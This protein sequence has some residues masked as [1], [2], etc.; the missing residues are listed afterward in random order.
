MQGRSALDTLYQAGAS[1]IL[2][3]RMT[4]QSLTAVTLNTAGGITGGDSFQLTARAGRDSHLTLT[5]QAA[6]RLY[7][8]QPGE[9]AAVSNTVEVGH[10][11]RLNWLP[12]ETI[13]FDGCAL[14]RSLT[15]DLAAD[16]RLL[17]VEPVIFGRTAMG[18]TVHR[19]LF[20]DR[21]HVRRAGKLIFADAV[22][23]EGRI[24]R[25]LDQPAIA[26][27]ARAMA[28]LLY[29]GEDAERFLAPL[30]QA[31]PG[32][33]GAS[34]IREDVLFARLLTPDSYLLRRSLMPVLETLLQSDLPR[35][36]TL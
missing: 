12:Q 7:R 30:R 34:L 18:E 25:H 16:T 26:P 20:L 5:T 32:I 21:I 8:S 24:A 27:G 28:T 2:L 31:M 10:G 6:E 1:R 35:T 17:L 33:G 9:V 23:L 3:P 14:R 36:W 4:G 29:V 15:A 11:A 13:L 19:G 22:R